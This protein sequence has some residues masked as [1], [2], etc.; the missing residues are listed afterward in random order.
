MNREI[1]VKWLDEISLSEPGESIFLATEN[2]SHAKE[3]IKLFKKEIRILFE[4]DPIKANKIQVSITAK[5]QRF[6]L[7]LQRTFGSPLV[8]FRKGADGKLKRIELADPERGRRLAL[9]QED[10]LTLEEVE[11]IEGEL[12]DEERRMWK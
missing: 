5:D 10:G 2:R 12:T 3:L 11:E 7:E 1:V 9:M 8:G 6:W 4:L